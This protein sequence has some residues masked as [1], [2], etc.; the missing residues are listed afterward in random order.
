MKAKVFKVCAFNALLLFICHHLFMAFLAG[1]FAEYP[2]GYA[3][4]CAAVA[5]VAVIVNYRLLRRESGRKAP[6]QKEKA[7]PKDYIRTLRSYY[8]KSEL[9]K[10][11][12]SAIAQI[13]RVSAKQKGL[14]M[15]LEQY[16]DKGEMTY[17]KYRENIDEVCALFYQNISTLT[18]TVVTFDEK[19]YRALR[20]NRLQLAPAMHSQKSQYYEEQFRLLT[21]LLYQNEEI[22]TTLDNLHLALSELSASARSESEK[23]QIL[24]EM[25]Q[26][27][28]HTSAYR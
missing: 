20:A 14:V 2:F 27:T 28:V 19:E 21:R 22:I 24:E 4:A 9:G 5:I 16:F 1:S 17:L 26:L 15:I 18:N 8:Y 25:R 13:E 11:V 7:A 12:N 6:P 10:Q 23:K 3:V